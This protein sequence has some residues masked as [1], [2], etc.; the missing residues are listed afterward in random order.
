MEDQFEASRSVG[1]IESA[2]PLSLPV[3]DQET[4]KKILLEERREALRSRL[5]K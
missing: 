5:K 2:E 3:P 4:V 1:K